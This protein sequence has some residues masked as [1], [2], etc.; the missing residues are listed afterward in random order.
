MHTS[1]LP[2]WWGRLPPEAPE[3]FM[4]SGRAHYWL[5]KMDQVFLF[6]PGT[7]RDYSN[8]GYLLLGEIIERVT[9]SRFEDAL[10]NLVLSRFGALTSTMED[11]RKPRGDYAKGYELNNNTLVETGYEPMPFAAGGLRSSVND[12]QSFSDALFGGILIKR[13]S[14]RRMVAHA[15]LKDGRPVEDGL[16]VAPG[17]P[18]PQSFDDTQELGYGLGV[19]TWVQSGE[20]FY[21]HAGLI[22]GF[23][24]YWIHSPRT[25]TS[26]IIL[27]NTHG[28]TNPL[29]EDLRAGLRAI[30]S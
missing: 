5:A 29:H 28:G 30:P 12:M 15:K 8:S 17:A 22:S 26:A 18:P 11:P 27:A 6:D 1:G 2:N 20:R 19:N 16:Y 21:S 9:Q 10:S 23:G 3:D 24:S 13:S 4:S 14:L 7:Y 25:K